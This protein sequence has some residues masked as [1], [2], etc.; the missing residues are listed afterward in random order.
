MTSTL[1]S[2]A[3]CPPGSCCGTP[4]APAR[5]LGVGPSVPF[6]DPA[7][8]A[9]LAPVLWLPETGAQRLDALSRHPSAGN[10]ADLT[11]SSLR[12]VR[13]VIRG[14]DNCEYLLLR[15]TERSVAI[16]LSGQRITQSP[17]CVAFLVHGLSRTKEV[18]AILAEL[19][20]LFTKAPRWVKPG[21]RRNLIRDAFVAIDARSAG[22]SHRDAAEA[23]FGIRR[24]REDWSGRG[25]ALKE[26][27]RRALA[28]GQYLCDGG[29]RQLLQEACRFR[30]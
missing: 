18:A 5:L 8:I 15:T 21:S 19:L 24:V 20:E 9:P 7:L 22:A 13:H 3:A 23:I 12:C 16:K 29:H 6:V 10:A 11:L 26:R 2:H 25:G 17:V 14:P 27:M 30:L 4:P 28:K 1:A